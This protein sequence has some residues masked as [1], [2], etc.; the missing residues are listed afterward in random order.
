[1]NFGAI[2]TVIAH[3]ITHAFDDIGK[4]FDKYGNNENW[5][6]STTDTMFKNRTQC[7]IN[8]YN[9]YVLQDIA[10]NLN[11]INTLGE[12]IADNVGVREA[13]KAYKSYV[14]QHPKELTLPGLRYTPEQLFWITYGN[15]W[16]TQVRPEVSKM[17]VDKETHSPARFRVIGTLSN[18]KE[19]SQSFNCPEGS[20][21]NPLNKC[22]IW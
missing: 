15:V 20:P 19:F 12:N 16:C 5:W 6:H 11:G 13:F 18:L 22:N 2:G 9:G 8:Q 10:T 14:K 1:M 17:F 3:E 4:Q 21:M 7:L